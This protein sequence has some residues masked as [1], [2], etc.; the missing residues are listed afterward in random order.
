[1]DDPTN[2]LIVFTECQPGQ[3]DEFN[4]WYDDV[5][6]DDMQAVE[7]IET[8]QRYRLDELNPAQSA[9]HRWLAIYQLSRPAQEVAAAL[10]AGSATRAPHS[11]AYDQSKTQFWYYSAI[12]R[13]T[14]GA[15]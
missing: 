9:P 6:I 5:H 1:M 15:G 7:G 8:I 2:I 4:R 14:P 11:P 13:Q 3:E 12:T 10:H